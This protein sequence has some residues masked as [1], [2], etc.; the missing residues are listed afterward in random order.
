MQIVEDNFAEVARAVVAAHEAGELAAAVAGGHD[1]YKA[2]VNG[3]GK[4]QKRKGKRLFMPLRVALTGRMQGPDVGDVL[5]AL[6]LESGADA[7]DRAAFAPLDARIE[8]LKRWAD[9]QAA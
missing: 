7:A 5:A 6:A 9:A 4:A 8:R 3:I 2:W 1:A